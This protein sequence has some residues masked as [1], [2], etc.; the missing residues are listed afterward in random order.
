MN[1]KGHSCNPEIPPSSGGFISGNVLDFTRLP[2]LTD[3]DKM[4]VCDFSKNAQALGFP[5][6]CTWI[7]I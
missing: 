4:E 5:H 2:A 7:N 6:V 1:S 3:S